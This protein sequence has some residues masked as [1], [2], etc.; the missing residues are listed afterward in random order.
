MCCKLP[1][2]HVRHQSCDTT[3]GDGVKSALQQPVQ[4]SN[5]CLRSQAAGLSLVCCK[6]LQTRLPNHAIP[7][8]TV[9]TVKYL[10]LNGK[11]HGVSHGSKS[12]GVTY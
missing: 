4:R 12:V 3:I 9:F 2:W 5:Q 1:D 7:F 6:A 11:S 10:N 8:S